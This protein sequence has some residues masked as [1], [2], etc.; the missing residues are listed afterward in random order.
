MRAGEDEHLLFAVGREA[1]AEPY[2][3]IQR[4]AA[5]PAA[6]SAANPPLT[7]SCRASSSFSRHAASAV[8]QNLRPESTIAAATCCDDSGAEFA[9]KFRRD[10]VPGDIGA[11]VGRQDGVVH[12]DQHRAGQLRHRLQG[13]F[14][15][16]G[17]DDRI[18]S[19]LPPVLRPKMVPRS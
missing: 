19:T 15:S 3:Q 8:A 10:V 14:T 16:G 9:G 1:V 4:Q 2:R 13:H 12:V 11:A 6:A 17:I 18:E 7:T 5:W